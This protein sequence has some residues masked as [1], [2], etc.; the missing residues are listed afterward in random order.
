L[1]GVEVG[2]EMQHLAIELGQSR[3]PLVLQC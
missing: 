1:V 3:D 2:Q